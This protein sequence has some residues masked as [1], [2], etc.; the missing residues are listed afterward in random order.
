MFVQRQTP[1]RIPD[2]G[3]HLHFA[4]M[5]NHFRVARSRSASLGF[6]S[7]STSFV[8]SYG[9]W[10]SVIPPTSYESFRNV[11]FIVPFGTRVLIGIVIS[12][13]VVSA[14]KT[15]RVFHRTR[16]EKQIHQPLVFFF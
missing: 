13:T 15:W 10:F 11:E 12:W 4:C 8:G 6:H 5:K 9:V 2:E 3:L 16:F 14:N 7:F 1:A